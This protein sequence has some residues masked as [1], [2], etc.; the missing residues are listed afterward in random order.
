ENL[1]RAR[2]W[3]FAEAHRNDRCRHRAASGP[4]PAHEYRA[5]SRAHGEDGVSR[6][7]RRQ[8]NEF[9]GVHAAQRP[10]PSNP[11]ASSSP[12]PSGSRGQI[13]RRETCRN[14]C[15]SNVARLEARLPPSAHRRSDEIRSDASARL[16][17][18]DAEPCGESLTTGAHTKITKVAKFLAVVSFV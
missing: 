12:G 9:V 3:Y 2:R 13:I 7:A 1:S 14:L 6:F 10:H 17:G 5:Q 18:S 11:G 8:R 4:S 16:R 15:A